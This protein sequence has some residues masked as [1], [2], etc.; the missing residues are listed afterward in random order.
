MPSIEDRSTVVDKRKEVGHFEDDTMVSRQSIVRIKSINERVSGVVFL[1]KM[2]NGTREESSRVM[3]ERLAGVPS[4]FR[5]TLT[6]DRGTENM[7]WKEIAH[8]L[9]M[10]VFFAYAYC[11]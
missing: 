4:I 3:C 11:S 5:K 6:R 1:S 8:N 7:G 10:D 2:K 9:S